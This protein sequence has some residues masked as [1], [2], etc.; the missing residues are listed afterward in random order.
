MADRIIVYWRDIPAQVIIKQGRKNAKRELSLRFTEAIDMAA[1]RTGAAESGEY[2]A[3]WRKADPTPVSDDL[4]AEADKAVTE[5][6]A[7]YDRERLVALVKAGGK[8]DV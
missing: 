1:M 3:E 5:I 7:A 4:E 6:E 8:D 2:L